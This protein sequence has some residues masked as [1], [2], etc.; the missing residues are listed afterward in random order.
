MKKKNY[1]RQHIRIDMVKVWLGG[2]KLQPPFIG[3]ILTCHDTANLVCPQPFECRDYVFVL[4]EGRVLHKGAWH[5]SFAALLGSLL[6]VQGHKMSNSY[7]Q[8][9]LQ[10]IINVNQ[11]ML[12]KSVFHDP[13]HELYGH[14]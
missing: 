5:G 9:S 2:W 4:L 1:F 13:R 7:V 14:L 12:I 10:R 3:S 11:F 8:Y 6:G